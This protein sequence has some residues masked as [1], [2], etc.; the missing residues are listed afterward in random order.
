MKEIYT[1]NASVTEMLKELQCGESLE[2]CREQSCLIMLYNNILKQN[3]CFPSEYIPEFHTETSQYQLQTRSYHMFKLSVPYCHADVYKYS[4]VPCS[5]RLWNSL[6]N[7]IVEATSA[8]SFKSLLHDHYIRL[9]SLIV[10]C[11]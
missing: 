9:N 3:I 8:S 7:Q 1:Y 5:S 6:P 10:N 11:V 4:V 2:S